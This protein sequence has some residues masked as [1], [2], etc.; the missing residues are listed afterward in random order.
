MKEE[1][2]KYKSPAQSS[3]ALQDKVSYV[4]CIKMRPGNV[5]MRAEFISLTGFANFEAA[6]NRS[7]TN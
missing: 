2:N 4:P 7:L 6:V 5:R 3:P 1:E